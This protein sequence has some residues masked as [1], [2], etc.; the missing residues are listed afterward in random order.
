M[1]DQQ[2]ESLKLLICIG[3]A[4]L[5]VLECSCT[6]NRDHVNIECG[7]A[8]HQLQIMMLTLAAHMPTLS[9]AQASAANLGE[10]AFH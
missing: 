7:P 4:R 2:G 9:P 6:G 8:G 5:K 10:I 3:G 1:A